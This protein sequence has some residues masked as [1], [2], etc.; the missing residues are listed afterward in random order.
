MRTEDKVEMFVETI[1]EQFTSKKD[2]SRDADF[3]KQITN[4]TQRIQRIEL[5]EVQ[6]RSITT[7][8]IAEIIRNFKTGNAL[9]R[10]KISNQMLK[11]L[12]EEYIDM[13]LK[14]QVNSIL[15]IQNHPKEQKK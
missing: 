3:Q 9:G 5:N 13:E 7:E 4:I 1:K 6:L 12:S 10:D 2:P 15:K 11:E 14:N 8:E